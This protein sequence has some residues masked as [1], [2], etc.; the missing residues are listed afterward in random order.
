M[1]RVQADIRNGNVLI[2]SIG[3]PDRK[4]NPWVF[5]ERLSLEGQLYTSDVV[6]LLSLQVNALS[7]N[8]LPLFRKDLSFDR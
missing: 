3:T 6:R 1:A 5:I 8:H 2:F 7:P 4:R